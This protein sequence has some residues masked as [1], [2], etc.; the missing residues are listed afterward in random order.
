LFDFGEPGTAG[1]D[2][3]CFAIRIPDRAP[4]Q[5]LGILHQREAA[6]EIAGLLGLAQGGRFE[7]GDEKGLERV[8]GAD[9]PCGDA[10]DTGIEEIQTDVGAGEQLV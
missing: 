9:G 2:V 7:Q 4:G 10:V 1:G 6:G 8:A 3:L 5:A